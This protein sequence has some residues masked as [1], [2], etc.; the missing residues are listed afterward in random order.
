MKYKLE[1]L[2]QGISYVKTE[3][4]HILTMKLCGMVTEHMM[5]PKFKQLWLRTILQKKLLKG[6]QESSP[7][8]AI[9]AVLQKRLRLFIQPHANTFDRVVLDAHCL[10]WELTELVR[11]GYLK[12]YYADSFCYLRQILF[13]QDKGSCNRVWHRTQWEKLSLFL[14]LCFCWFAGL[15][16]LSGFLFFFFVF[17]EGGVNCGDWY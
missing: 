3:G 9:L 10:K 12:K 16:L 5:C 11:N 8:G 6:R 15:V 7:W 2:V 17:G 4:Q 13:I 1:T 14:F